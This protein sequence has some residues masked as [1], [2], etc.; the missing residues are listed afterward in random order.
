MFF[1]SM[2]ESLT[3][4]LNSK[5]IIILCHIIYSIELNKQNIIENVNITFI[6]FQ[7]ISPS[8]IK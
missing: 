7:Y 1:K 4:N 8:F 2:S 6:I 3:S 5:I